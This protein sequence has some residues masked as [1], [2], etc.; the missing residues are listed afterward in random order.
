[1]RGEPARTDS[2][3]CALKYALIYVQLY[4]ELYPKLYSGV[5]GGRVV[6]GL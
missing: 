5:G 3:K 6:L 1:M 4:P 2:G